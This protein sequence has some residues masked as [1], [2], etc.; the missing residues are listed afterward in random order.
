MYRRLSKLERWLLIIGVPATL[1]QR[2]A[3]E[4][5][6]TEFVLVFTLQAITDKCFI[7]HIHMEIPV[8]SFMPCRFTFVLLAVSF[9]VVSTVLYR[10]CMLAYVHNS[11]RY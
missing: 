11:H 8:A 3:I 4:S 10:L 9:V 2:T 6:K 5:P 7:K 1:T